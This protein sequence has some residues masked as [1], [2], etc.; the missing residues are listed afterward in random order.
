MPTFG[1]AKKAKDDNKWH[2]AW[3]I[4]GKIFTIRDGWMASP[5]VSL[6]LKQLCTSKQKPAITLMQINK[7]EIISFSSL[8]LLKF[9]SSV[10]SCK[11]CVYLFC[12]CISL[13]CFYL[14]SSTDTI[15]HSFL[16][17]PQRKVYAHTL[18]QKC[19]AHP[20]KTQRG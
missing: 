12:I 2:S 19:N 1:K 18:R 11:V 4:E 20:K 7:V 13:F 10:I 17:V 8:G 15:I 3:T 16:S 14:A 5:F 6:M 9:V